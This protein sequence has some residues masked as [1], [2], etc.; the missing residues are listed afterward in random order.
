MLINSKKVMPMFEAGGLHNWLKANT[1]RRSGAAQK[2]MELVVAIVNEAHASIADVD[3]EITQCYG[4]TSMSDGLLMVDIRQHGMA[5][6]KVLGCVVLVTKVVP[7][8]QEELIVESLCPNFTAVDMDAY[9]PGYS[10]NADTFRA[11]LT[12]YSGGEGDGE[13]LFVRMLEEFVMN[14]ELDLTKLRFRRGNA[15]RTATFARPGLIKLDVYLAETDEVL[16]T[17]SIGTGCLE[18]DKREYIKRDRFEFVPTDALAK[19]VPTDSLAQPAQEAETMTTTTDVTVKLIDVV[20]GARLSGVRLADWMLNNDASSEVP[21]VRARIDQFIGGLIGECDANKQLSFTMRRIL[22]TADAKISLPYKDAY[23]LID[24]VLLLEDRSR[25]VGYRVVRFFTIRTRFEV[26]ND[27]LVREVIDKV[28]DPST[29][30]IEPLQ[31]VNV[32]S[33]VPINNVNVRSYSLPEFFEFLSCGNPAL[34]ESAMAAIEQIKRAFKMTVHQSDQINSLRVVMNTLNHASVSD[35]H[36]LTEGVIKGMVYD[37]P[38]DGRP[39]FSFK[40]MTDL[41]TNPDRYVVNEVVNEFSIP[42]LE[43][44]LAKAKESAQPVT[45]VPE[46]I[47]MSSPYDFMS[48]PPVVGEAV[49]LVPRAKGP[50]EVARIADRL[51]MDE[52]EF[53]DWIDNNLMPHNNS[54]LYRNIMLRIKEKRQEYLG[55]LNT[56]LLFSVWRQGAD[57]IIVAVDRTDERARFRRQV[58]NFVLVTRAYDGAEKINGM[59]PEKLEMPE[60]VK[61]AIADIAASTTEAKAASDTS[62]RTCAFAFLNHALGGL[63]QLLTDEEQVKVRAFITFIDQMYHH[64]GVSGEYFEVGFEEHAALSIDVFEGDNDVALASLRLQLK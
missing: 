48:R 61:Q 38:Y 63:C 3:A 16:G 58:F 12:I 21:E 17:Y 24:V 59:L 15:R 28:L 20:Q 27:G 40:V 5:S 53:R 36:L 19:Y 30:V 35:K 6:Y 22:P 14:H 50:I 9:S 60:V 2:A 54:D 55:D 62:F 23:G 57:Q 41:S 39:L 42:A 18:P 33:C 7:G 10:A 49:E 29:R 11:W 44:E 46:K 45:H 34:E 37:T 64:K 47:R 32:R 4:A 25:G 8:Q 51:Q 43:E 52:E 1:G 56:P 26:I 13:A 31:C